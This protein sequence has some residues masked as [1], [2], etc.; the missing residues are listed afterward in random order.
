MPALDLLPLLGRR[1][2]VAALVQVAVVADL[3]A[4]LDDRLDRLRV[5]L[6]RVAGHVERAP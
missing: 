3:V 1:D 2:R 6:G 5:P 4:G